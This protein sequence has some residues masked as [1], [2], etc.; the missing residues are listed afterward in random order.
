MIR[1]PFGNINSN[2]PPTISFGMFDFAVMLTV[3]LL[4]SADVTFAYNDEEYVIHDLSL[5]IPKGSS[6]AFVGHTGSGKSTVMNLIYKFYNINEG[7]I[8]ID[9]KD[10]NDLDMVKVREN[11]AIVFQNPYIFEGTIYENIALFDESISVLHHNL[12]EP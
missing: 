3:L 7:K 4:V 8:L 6:A 11:M 12:N 1:V 10:L 9:G 5:D 2:L